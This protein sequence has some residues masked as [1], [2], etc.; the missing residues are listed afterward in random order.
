VLGQKGKQRGLLLA[1]A[2]WQMNNSEKYD[3]TIIGAGIVGI[4][5]GIALLEKNSKKKVAIV[6]KE[7][8]PGVHASGRNSGVLH[9]G[10]YYS[11]DSLKAKFCKVGNQELSEY[12]KKNNLPFKNIGKVVVTKDSSE[13]GRLRDLFERGLKNGINLELLPQKELDKIEP[14]ANTSQ[15]FIWSPTTSIADPKLVNLSL[16]D[17]FINLGGVFYFDQKAKLVEKNGV[18]ELVLN[19]KTF[20]TETIINSSGA[21]AAMLAKQVGVGKEF[22]C[23]P[24]LGSY[25]RSK[26]NSQTPTKLIYPVPNPVNPFLGV[27]TTNTLSGDIKLGPTAF[28]V[29]GKEQYKLTEGFN[30]NELREFIVA[31]KSMMKSKSMDF[32]SLAF[33][34]LL[35]QFKFKVVSNSK[36]LSDTIKLNNGWE[37][38]PAGIRA[39]IVNLE[40]N[41]LEMDYIVRSDKNVV[42]VLN[43]VS[44]GWTSA[45]PFGRWVV[46]NQP[47]L[48]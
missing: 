44:P 1:L 32:R 21:A 3:Y 38:Y 46:E 47:L 2:S 23:L 48:S 12:C 43:A 33:T 11:P 27:H 14:S 9:A 24:F 16:A 36:Y 13:I 17:K 40:N 20:P 29:I 26:Q 35:K 15:E 6:D 39:Q 34:E 41:S 18:V 22:V 7:L 4:A 8:Q 10:F 31:S 30:F 37:K 45:L 42:H 28:P 25:W 5:I 19:S